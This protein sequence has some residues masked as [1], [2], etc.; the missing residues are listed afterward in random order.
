[1]KKATGRIRT[2]DL[3]ITNLEAQNAN[4][5]GDK[6]LQQSK[7]TMRAPQGAELTSTPD[8]SAEST[9]KPTPEITPDHRRVEDPQLS[10]LITLWDEL[11]PTVRECVL[12]MMEQLKHK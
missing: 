8:I 5:M 3:Q 12:A 11:T 9:P 10:K 7:N 1:M 6:D 4:G 2:G